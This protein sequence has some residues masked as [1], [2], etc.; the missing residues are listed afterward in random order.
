MVSWFTYL[1]MALWP[2]QKDYYAYTPTEFFALEA[3]NQTIDIQN[4]DTE[5]LEAAI[6]QASNEVRLQQKK[7]TFGPNDLLHKAARQHAVYLAKSK[8]VDHRNTR[9]KKLATPYKRVLAYGGD[10]FMGVAENLALISPVLLGKDNMYYIKNGEPVDKQGN[11]LPVS[12]YAQFARK[13]LEGW[14]NSKG[15]RENLMGPYTLLGCAISGISF[16][17]DNVPQVTF[18][19]NFGYK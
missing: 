2:A 4:L 3:V 17:R 1:F 6:F 5:L 7:D 19:Q 15:H 13:A 8:K 18:V 11:P 14:M 10:D 9:N 12:T 16:N